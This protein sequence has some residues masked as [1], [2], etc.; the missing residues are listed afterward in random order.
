MCRNR[1]LIPI[2]GPE[3][4]NLCH[5]WPVCSLWGM[6]VFYAFWS[7]SEDLGAG[8]FRPALTSAWPDYDSLA[9]TKI[10][11]VLLPFWGILP[12]FLECGRSEIAYFYYGFY[13]LMN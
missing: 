6:A 11:S 5:V 2:N 7:R 8:Y 13:G 10:M 4:A 3:S 12:L 9:R 1:R